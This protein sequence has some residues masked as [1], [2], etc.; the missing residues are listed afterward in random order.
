MDQIVKPKK[1]YRHREAPK[2]YRLLQR[3][4]LA[5]PLVRI[6]GAYWSPSLEHMFS[7]TTALRNMKQLGGLITVRDLPNNDYVEI[8][9]LLRHDLSKDVVQFLAQ[10]KKLHAT[11][12]RTSKREKPN[13]ARIE[14]P[15]DL[16]RA[17]TE[18]MPI[19][20]LLAQV[21]DRHRKQRASEGLYAGYMQSMSYTLEYT[22][23]A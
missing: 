1:R 13:V 4:L 7:H 22:T 21:V 8:M 2:S 3:A 20:L 18:I 19:E 9:H 6:K 5:G 16:V 17:A 11:R 14:L 10:E 12:K 15:L 23:G